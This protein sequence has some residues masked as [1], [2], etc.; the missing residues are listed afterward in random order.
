MYSFL[1]FLCRI[2]LYPINGMP[3]FENKQR[4]PE[5]NYILVAPHRTWFD[6]LYFALA[7]SPKEFAFIAKKELF[8]NP[9]L[10]YV[11]RH[12]NV[13]SVDRENPGPSVIKEPVKILQN[14]DKSLII[15]PSGTRHS[16]ALKGGATLIAKLSKAPLLPAVYQGPLTFKSLFSRK[17]AVINF[18][19]PIYLDKS[20]KLNEEG[21]KAV[22]QQMQDAFDKLDKEINPD[23]KYVDPSSKK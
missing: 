1:K 9:L 15:F 11:L 21:Q 8:K 7:A 4:I 5:G 10:A 22:E 14:T 20:I 2:I 16:Q 13:L 6:P 19:E 23:F 3:K 17:K 12:A 18:G